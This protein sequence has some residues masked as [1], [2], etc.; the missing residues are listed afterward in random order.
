MGAGKCVFF[1]GFFFFLDDY[2]SVNA[3]LNNSSGN[4]SVNTQVSNLAHIPFVLREETSARA[5]ICTSA[6]THVPT[7]PGGRQILDTTRGSRVMT[8]E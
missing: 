4:I 2:Y 3:C 7:A 6:F 8:D 1:W 5:L